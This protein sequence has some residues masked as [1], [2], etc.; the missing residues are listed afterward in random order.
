MRVRASLAA[1]ALALLAACYPELDWREFRSDE[2]RFV[3]QVIVDG[4]YADVI[5]MAI[6]E[7]RWGG[8]E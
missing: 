2:G 3:A 5:R 8:V 7:S 1:L 4:V 6:T